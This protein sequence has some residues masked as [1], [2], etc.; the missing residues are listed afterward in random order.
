MN[1]NKQPV[2]SYQSCGATLAAGAPPWAFAGVSGSTAGSVTP[3]RAKKNLP[4]TCGLK[5][6]EAGRD[7]LQI[8]AFSDDLGSVQWRYKLVPGS[9]A[10]AA[11]TQVPAPVV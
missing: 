9:A 6:R 1:T 5:I 2:A 8:L 4:A 11:T 3:M 7:V 10:N